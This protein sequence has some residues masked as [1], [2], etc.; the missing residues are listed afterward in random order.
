MDQGAPSY[1]FS[2]PF[3]GGGWRIEEFMALAA[4]LFSS[5]DG[6]AECPRCRGR[7]SWAQPGTLAGT[8]WYEEAPSKHYK[9]HPC[10]WCKRMISGRRRFCNDQCNKKFYYRQKHPSIRRKTPIISP[11]GRE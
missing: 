5:W 10:E 3:C 4:S 8:K 11:S 6:L 9:P 1:S 2:C 7:F